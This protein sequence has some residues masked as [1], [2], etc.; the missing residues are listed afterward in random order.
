MIKIEARQLIV[1]RS[2]K[3]APKEAWD[4]LTDTTKWPSWG[5]SIRRVVSSEQY[6]LKGS[7]GQV[8]TPFG[9]VL[10]FIITEYV[11]GEYWSWIVAGL[12]ATGH[13]LT[14]HGSGSCS[15][16]FEMPLYWLPYCLICLLALKRMA[17]LLEAEAVGHAHSKGH[18]VG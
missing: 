13:R 1:E 18:P 4:L 10:P 16:A 7:W 2:F 8:C 9:L 6:I 12:R 15:I 11:P 5:P 17:G 14:P 3:A